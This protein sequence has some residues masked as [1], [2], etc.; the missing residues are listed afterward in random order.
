[1]LYHDCLVCLIVL[2]AINIIMVE[3]A[4]MWYTI[5]RIQF[6]CPVALKLCIQMWLLFPGLQGTP[7]EEKSIPEKWVRP[8]QPS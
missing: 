4:N 1:M 3:I 6:N 2:L 5:I 7:Q 8:T